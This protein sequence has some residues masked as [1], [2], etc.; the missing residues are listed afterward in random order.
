MHK[1][2]SNMLWFVNILCKIV[3]STAVYFSYFVSQALTFFCSLFFPFVLFLGGLALFHL[4]EATGLTIFFS[5][6]A[7]SIKYTGQAIPSLL[8]ISRLLA[9]KCNIYYKSV[10]SQVFT[11]LRFCS[12]FNGI[13][14][15]KKGKTP[16]PQISS[17]PKS[18][19][20]IMTNCSLPD[21]ACRIRQC[22][23]KAA[24]SQFW[25]GL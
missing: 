2:N 15:K 3:K 20:S 8:T 21:D 23:Y 25:N 1:A 10:A 22:F 16:I 18:C 9:L 4:K 13:K 11:I 24:Q 6:T 17:Y 7:N 19:Y 5:A 14:K 12:H